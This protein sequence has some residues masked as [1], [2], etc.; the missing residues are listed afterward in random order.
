MTIARSY[1]PLHPRIHADPY[2]TYREMRREAPVHW[3][4]QLQLWFLSKHS[5]VTC[6]LRDTSFSSAQ[7]L[8]SRGLG[9]SLIFT[10][11]P[12]H[13]RLRALVG[14]AF[15]PGVIRKL[16]SRITVIV[17]DLLDRAAEKNEMEFVSDFA[18]PFPVT[19]IAEL[20]GVPAEDRDRFRQWADTLAYGVEPV[21]SNDTVERVR[22]ARHEL[23]SY[24]AGIASIRRQ[25]PQEDLISRLAT[26]EERGDGLTE[27]ELL[28]LCGQLLVAGHFTTSN[29]LGSGMLALLQHPEQLRSLRQEANLLDSAIEEL[30]RYTS[31]TQFMSRRA[32]RD[33]M[34]SGHHI[35][36]GQLVVTMVAAANR[37]PEV[38]R[39]C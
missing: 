5:D 27:K 16:Q 7:A 1:N 8:R 2:P 13:T 18:H 21:V 31:P 38:F 30:L 36:A 37:D 4:D 12:D 3:H 34:L 19:V 20:L 23:S 28:A 26:V 35:G 6:V 24:L 9:S 15:T 32:T 25:A 22:A 33:A 17:H 10:D 14:K 11:P 39:R 29:F